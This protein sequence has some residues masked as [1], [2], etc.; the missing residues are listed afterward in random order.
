MRKRC[1]KC[2]RRRGV[3][4]FS[5][6]DCKADGRQTYCRDCQKKIRAGRRVQDQAKQRE[7]RAA[8][9][10]AARAACR[11]YYHSHR[12]QRLKT[13]SRWQRKNGNMVAAVYRWRE[14]NPE[15][16]RAIEQRRRCRLA[17]AEGSFTAEEWKAKKILFGNRCAYCRKRK[18]LTVHH[19]RPI[20][21]GGSNFAKNIVPACR[22]C[23]SSIGTKV[24]KPRRV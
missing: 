12:D 5:K 11:R 21:R 24:I 14:R 13:M 1:P 4:E 18:P 16:F 19:V 15:G 10:D 7:W 6:D 8:N 2:E 3:Q 22:A 20:S 23:N 9:R 17:K